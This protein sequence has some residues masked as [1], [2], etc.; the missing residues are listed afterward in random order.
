[1]AQ[2]IKREKRKRKEEANQE[3]DEGKRTKDASEPR[4]PS[5]I[6]H[7]NPLALTVPPL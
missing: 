7:L 3:Q 5:R 1:M 6:L 2:R 4:V